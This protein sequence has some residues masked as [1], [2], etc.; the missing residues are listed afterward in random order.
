MAVCQPFSRPCPFSRGCLWQVSCSS[1]PFSRVWR[2]LLPFQGSCRLLE[3]H[4]GFS[5]CAL[6]LS[7]L[8]FVPYSGRGSIRSLEW[9]CQFFG[10]AQ[11]INRNITSGLLQLPTLLHILFQGGCT[12]F[13]GLCLHPFSRWLHPFS[14]L[15]RPGPFSRQLCSCQKAGVHHQGAVPFSRYP[16]PVEYSSPVKLVQ[17]DWSPIPAQP[18][19]MKQQSSQALCPHLDPNRTL[20]LRCVQDRLLLDH[21]VQSLPKWA[22]V[23]FC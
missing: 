21:L 8:F 3:A 4:G 6:L 7:K 13:Q 17:S 18:P 14:R 12:L 2:L 10:D 23:N 1:N 11:R 9:T 22:R 15:L 5:G 16:A 19:D 20:E